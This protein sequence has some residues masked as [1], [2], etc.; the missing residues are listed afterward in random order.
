MIHYALEAVAAAGIRDVGIVINPDTGDDIRKG[1]GDGSHSVSGDA[2][3]C[4][5][6]P[7]AW[8]T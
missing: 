4:K 8:P 2:T 7:W 1:L 5:R 6:R 3:C